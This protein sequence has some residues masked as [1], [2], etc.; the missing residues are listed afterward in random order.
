MNKAVS[1]TNPGYT[2]LIIE[3]I[4]EETKHFKT[5]A[6]RDGHNIHYEAGQFI[7]LVDITGSREI[8]RSYSIVSS[9]VLNEPL[10]I[11]V[12]RIDNG[13][14]SRKLVDRT[15]V[16]NSLLT[17]GAAGFFRLPENIKFF[18]SIFFFS[19]SHR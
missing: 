7:T 1:F 15:K 6:F 14:F 10:A 4:R 19:A 12:K 2:T 18:K 8:R 17:S 11:A 5:F 3:D 13:Y 16:G 9:P